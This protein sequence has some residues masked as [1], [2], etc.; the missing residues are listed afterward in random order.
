MIPNCSFDLH[1]SDNVILSIF[2]CAFC[3]SICLIWR[4]VYLDLLL[5]FL[6]GFC[7]WYTVSELFYCIFGRLSFVDCFACNNFLPFCRLSFRFCLWVPLLCK[8]LKVWLG[9]V[10]SFLF[11]FL[12][13]WLGDWPKKTLV[14]FISENVRLWSHLGLLWCP[15]L[16]LS[17]YAILSFCMR[18]EGVLYLTERCLK[19]EWGEGL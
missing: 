13:S 15:V 16:C 2:S 19:A 3:P 14:Q 6:I 5:I 7:F 10:C 18:W 1:F 12:L 17:L 8:S 11:L 4:N 9:P